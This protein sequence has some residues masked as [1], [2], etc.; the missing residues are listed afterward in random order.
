LFFVFLFHTSDSIGALVEKVESGKVYSAVKNGKRFTIKRVPYETKDEV[1]FADSEERTLKLL[2]GL[3][4]YIM[5]FE[6]SFEDV[7]F[8]FFLLLFFLFKVVKAL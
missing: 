7:F 2:N 1:E 3:C 6:D 4:P 5:T 8:C